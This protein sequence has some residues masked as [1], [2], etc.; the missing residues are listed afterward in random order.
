MSKTK[1]V[2]MIC[3]AGFATSTAGE[4]E[5]T[6]IAKELG[7]KVV[8]HKRRATELNTVI[9]TMQPDFYLL[10]TPVSKKLNA[11]SVNGVALIS[12][13]NKEQCLQE[14][15]ELLSE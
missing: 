14:I 2:V 3:G 15:R 13:V 5:V 8:T 6:Q 9:N 12:G 11:P 4:A 7:V 1:T 10:M